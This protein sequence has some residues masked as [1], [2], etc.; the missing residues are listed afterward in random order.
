MATNWLIVGTLGCEHLPNVLKQI[1]SS[2]CVA[3]PHP[4]VKKHYWWQVQ[5]SSTNRLAPQPP[6]HCMLAQF[7]TLGK[8][9]ETLEQAEVVLFIVIHLFPD[10]LCRVNIVWVMQASFSS[11]QCRNW[12]LWAFFLKGN[13]KMTVSARYC[14]CSIYY[15]QTD[16]QFYIIIQLLWSCCHCRSNTLIFSIMQYF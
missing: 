1:P 13:S 8:V 16:F 15:P 3:V 2:P 14:Y 10:L 5:D 7:G 4:E 12:V 9:W 6:R 11:K